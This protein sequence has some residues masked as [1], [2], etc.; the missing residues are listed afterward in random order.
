MLGILSAQVFWRLFLKKQSY[1]LDNVHFFKF[2]SLFGKFSTFVW[3]VFENYPAKSVILPQPVALIEITS[4]ENFI[5]ASKYAHFERKDDLRTS[6]I[7]EVLT[8]VWKF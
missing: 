4:S 6:S 2:C 1:I 5:C 8:V 3:E 7:F